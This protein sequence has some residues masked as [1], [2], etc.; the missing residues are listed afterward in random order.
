MAT[1]GSSTANSTLQTFSVL[2]RSATRRWN[3]R[4]DVDGSCLTGWIGRVWKR[5]LNDYSAIRLHPKTP[6]SKWSASRRCGKSILRVLKFYLY[7][8]YKVYLFQ[9]K[10]VIIMIEKRNNNGGFLG[11]I[12]NVGC[13]STNSQSLWCTKM[14]QTVLRA[15]N[16]PALIRSIL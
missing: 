2:R 3:W 12:Y 8:Y 6:S 10:R 16:T 13:K 5:L 1:W 9:W 14:K 15:I 7:E 4:L 11:R